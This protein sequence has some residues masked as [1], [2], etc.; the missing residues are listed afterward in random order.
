MWSR[1]D[2]ALADHRKVIA[3]AEIIGP[4]GLVIALGFYLL[5]LLWANKHLSDGQLPAA[6][7]K[8][9]RSDRPLELADA[10]V[11]A[12]LWDRVDGGYQ[13]HD[14]DHLNFTAAEVKEK[15]AKDRRRKHDGRA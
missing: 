9:F 2:D 10:L 4:D 14:F 5:G 13:I 6:V 8:Q 11:R 1:V 12:G 15:R 7:V 3:A